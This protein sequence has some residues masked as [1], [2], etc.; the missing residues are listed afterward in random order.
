[1][2]HQGTRPG[3]IGT[4]RDRPGR[5][6]FYIRE[7][8]WGVSGFRLASHAQPRTATQAPLVASMYRLACNRLPAW[9]VLDR[10]NHLRDI[11]EM[12]PMD[13]IPNGLDAVHVYTY[14]YR[15]VQVQ[16]QGCITA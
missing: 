5:D 12:V 2:Q 10:Q 8:G 11:R 14:R 4:K 3:Q 7:N 1:M 6:A 13:G 15:P 16:L 9:R